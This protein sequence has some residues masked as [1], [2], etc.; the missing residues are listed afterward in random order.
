MWAFPNVFWITRLYDSPG[1]VNTV[2]AWHCSV[3]VC[4]CVLVGPHRQQPEASRLGNVPVRACES[5]LLFMC[6]QAH[7]SSCYMLIFYV[8]LRRES[9]LSLVCVFPA[10]P[11]RCHLYSYS[12]T[13]SRLRAAQP[14]SAGLRAAALLQQMMI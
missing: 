3:R 9:R 8:Q 14:S 4:V 7:E 13:H 11:H 10:L 6:M 1:S 2:H 5:V 12:Y